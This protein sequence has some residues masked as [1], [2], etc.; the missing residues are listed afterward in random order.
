MKKK[1]VGVKYIAICFFLLTPLF[2]AK[3]YSKVEPVDIF[4]IA[5][6][7][8]GEVVFADE[9][10]LGKKLDKTPFILIDAK[11]DV[12]ELKAVTKKIATLEEMIQA[13]KEIVKNLQESLV[14]KKQNYE[15]IKALSVKSK[16]QKDTI[17]F[18]L[19]A[20]KNQL[21]NTKKELA[22][23]MSQV[24]DL[25]AKK[26]RLEKSI[27]DKTITKEGYVLYEL[28]VKKGDVATPAKP[29][30][31]VAD[32]SKAILTLYVDRDVLEG[33]DKKTVFI[34]G[35]KTAYKV[36]RVI[37]I[38]D[39]VNLSKYK[40]QIIIDAPKIFSKLVKVEIQ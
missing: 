40:V 29:L 24:G 2:G 11:V 6:S 37:P 36:S 38:A 20:T 1:R 26:I 39:S 13:D 7:V 17:Y 28:Y 8:Q 34:D 33:I 9:S 15:N 22:N 27:H 25:E 3:Y 23:Y 30:A 32:T 10:K 4:T 21:L 19:I 35:K 5:S 14:R 31:K 16:I 18:D 12:A